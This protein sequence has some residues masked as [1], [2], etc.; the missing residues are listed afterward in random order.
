LEAALETPGVIAVKF[1]VT[2]VLVVRAFV[3]ITG[4]QLL[5]LLLLLLSASWETSD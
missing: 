4:E 5:L 3:D 2:L 1:V